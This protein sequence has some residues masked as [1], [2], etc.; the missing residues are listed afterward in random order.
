MQDLK[1]NKKYQELLEKRNRYE[2]KL[3]GFYRNFRG[4]IHEDSS[5]EMKY[6]QIKV[7]ES[8]IK[9]IDEELKKMMAEAT[10]KKK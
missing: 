5:S 2:D 7:Y 4:V 10:P 6:T 8:F 1:D 9:S 3:E